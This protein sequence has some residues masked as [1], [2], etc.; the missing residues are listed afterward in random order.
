MFCRRTCPRQD[1]LKLD[2]PELRFRVESRR[3]VDFGSAREAHPDR[4][5]MERSAPRQDAN[6]VPA[7]TRRRGGAGVGWP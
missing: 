1:D 2:L 6:V 7:G 5:R 4:V 3:K